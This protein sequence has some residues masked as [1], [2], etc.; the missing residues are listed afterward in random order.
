MKLI[1]AA[2]VVVAMVSGQAWGQCEGSQNARLKER[3]GTCSSGGTVL[4]AS[5]EHEA[6]TIVEVAK[7]A[8]SFGTLVA[9]VQ[10]AGLDGVLNGAGP[11]TVLAPTDEAFEALPAGTVEHL[12]K[13]E[14][15]GLLQAILLYHVIPAQVG[16][17]AIVK[18]TSVQTAGGQ[19]VDVDVRDGRVYVD[20]A[21]VILA[22]VGASNGV[23]HAINRVIMPATEDIVGT[24]LEAG[25]FNT[26]A[27]ALKAAALV[28]TLRGDGPFTVFAPT[29]EAFAAL[30]RGTVEGLLKP[31]NRD[32]LRGVLTYHVVAGRVYADDAVGVGVAATVE[33][34]DV[35]IRIKDGRLIVNDATVVSSDIETSNGVIHVIDRVILPPKK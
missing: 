15:K 28:E 5:M 4:L 11:F 1:G 25:S 27:A 31:E 3:A 24:A 7:A 17:G 18:E 13:P 8:G 23:I 16:S 32:A 14:N 33:G 2:A 34:S 6:G 9:A 26:L 30:P 19:R 29:D 22:D 21:Q 12:L 10:A 20:N 35:R